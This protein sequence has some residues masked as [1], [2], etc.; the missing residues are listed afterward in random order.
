MPCYE[1]VLALDLG[2]NPE[3]KKKKIKILPQRVDYN[4]A[5][6]KDRYGDALLKLPCGHCLGCLSEYKQQWAV[7]ILLEASNYD[8][9]CFIT[10]TYRDGFL[11][12][13]NKPHRDEFQRFMKRL[14][15]EIGEVRVFYCGE[16]GD[17]TGRAH[18]HAILFGYDFPDKVLHGR[19]RKGSLIYRSAILEKCWPYGM[20]SVGE[21]EPGSACYV[22]QYCNKKKLTGVDD[23]SFV[24]MSRRPGLGFQNFHLSWFNTDTI[25]C[26][27]GE[28]TIPRFYGK[29]LE[30]LKPE[31][32][33]V[34]KESRISRAKQRPD[35][36]FYHALACEEESLIYNY[37]IELRDKL[38]KKRGSL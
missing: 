5:M 33:Q 11:P 6:L 28:A 20:S 9:N 30:G 2:V 19:T 29:L 4:F 26:A 36:R 16:K 8:Q 38:K 7:R 3:T 21:L 17:S 27:L 37:E 35:S 34:W 12:K 10:L 22:A 13:D 18:Y 25:Y 15:K 14:R 24:G 32:Y 31:F 1:P 23:G